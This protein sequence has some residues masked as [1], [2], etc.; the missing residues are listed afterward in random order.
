MRDYRQFYINGEWV[1]P[2][3]PNDFDVINPATEEVC[4]QISLGS[5]DDVNRAVS[6]ARSAFDSYSR[7]TRQERIELLQSCVEIYQK[8]YNDIA[9]AIREEMGAPAEL[10]KGA[11]AFTGMGHLQEAA[12]VL[13]DFAFEEDLGEHRVFKEPIGVCGLITPWNWPVRGVPSW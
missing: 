4:A 2:V 8:Y 5:E 3:T 13:Q 9:D 7:T 10:A 6:A 1:D 12:K 11:Q